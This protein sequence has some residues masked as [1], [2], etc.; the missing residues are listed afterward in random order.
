MFQWLR[1]LLGSQSGD[2][3]VGEHYR[4][5]LAK[6]QHKDFDGAILEYTAVLDAPDVSHELCAMALYNRA[7]AHRF[8]KSY[9][10]AL[11]DL[12]HLLAMDGLRPHI[13][14]AAIEKRSQMQRVVDGAAH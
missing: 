11:A 5:G 8:K 4:S 10:A 12:E 9:P 7:I 2:G 14:K 3:A 6:A 13:R 1:G